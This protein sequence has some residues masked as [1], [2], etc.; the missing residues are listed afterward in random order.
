MAKKIK[1][2]KNDLEHLVNY[3]VMMT[4]ELE[5]AKLNP[6]FNFTWESLEDISTPNTLF[7]LETWQD[8]IEDL[9]STDEKPPKYHV[10]FVKALSKLYKGKY[11]NTLKAEPKNSLEEKKTIR[12]KEET[13]HLVNSMSSLSLDLIVFLKGKT[14]KGLFIYQYLTKLRPWLNNAYEDIDWLN[15]YFPTEGDLTITEEIEK[16]F[17]ELLRNIETNKEKSTPVNWFYFNRIWPN[18]LKKIINQSYE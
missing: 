5:Q 6:D 15:S 1:A 10:K 4:R 9:H 3:A 14:E 17:A 11:S 8:E 12:Y 18:M 16:Y 2:T 13:E 7:I